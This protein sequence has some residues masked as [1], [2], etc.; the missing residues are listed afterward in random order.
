[1][2]EQYNKY[3]ITYNQII[4]LKESFNYFD[5]VLIVLNTFF[6]NCNIPVKVLTWI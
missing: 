2:L 1:M 3:S 6:I 4:Y 5:Y